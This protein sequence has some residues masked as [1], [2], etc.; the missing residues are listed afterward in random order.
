[1]VD[2]EGNM[3]SVA[4]KSDDLLSGPVEDEEDMTSIMSADQRKALQQAASTSKEAETLEG[5]TARP[6][7]SIE[8]IAEAAAL[9]IPKAPAAPA[10]RLDKPAAV[11]EKV[12][13][14]A[15]ASSGWSTWELVAF[16]LL[17][18]AVAAA[19]RM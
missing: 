8:A 9:A 13:A 12:A 16:A 2:P 4:P 11:T 5:D 17:A 18:L 7:P 6:P 1:M 3:T 15:P 19:L 10:V 14:R